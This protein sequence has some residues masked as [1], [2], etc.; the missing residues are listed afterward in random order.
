M[1]SDRLHACEFFSAQ[2]YLSALLLSS[3]KP[4]NVFRGLTVLKVKDVNFRKGL[5]ILQFTISVVLIAASI[6]IYKQMQFIQKS[7]PGYNR[8]QVLSFRMAPTP[9]VMQDKNVNLM[10]NIKQELLRQSGIR[11]V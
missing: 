7:N 5:V 9:A 3:F 10:Q 4:L 8:A 1:E 6:I 11:N 2:Q